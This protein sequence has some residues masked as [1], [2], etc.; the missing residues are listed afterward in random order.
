M[1]AEAKNKSTD[2]AYQRRWRKQHPEKET[3][4]R[5]RHAARKLLA[6]GYTVEVKVKRPDGLE[7]TDLV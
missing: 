1:N 7:V 6:M 2:A 5:L 3:E 4:Y